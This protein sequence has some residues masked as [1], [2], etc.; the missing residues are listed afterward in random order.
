[1]EVD[2]RNLR[3]SFYQG[4]DEVH[5]FPCSPCAKNRMNVA[6]TKHCE[7][8]DENLCTKCLNHHN[9]FSLMKGDQLLDKLKSPSGHRPD[10]PSQ[11]CDRHGGKLIDVY[12]PSHDK[13]GCSTCIAVDHST[14]QRISFIPD[15][16]KH[17]RT[18]TKDLQ[19]LE[20][21]LSSLESR[22]IA[23]KQKKQK[24]LDSSK[25]EKDKL[26]HEINTERKKINEQLDKMETELLNE[27]DASFKMKMQ[28]IDSDIKEVEDTLAS[29][30]KDRQ[31]IQAAKSEN[32][33]EKYV[34]VKLGHERKKI[35]TYR[36]ETLEGSK[37]IGRL[38]FDPCHQIT[39]S[40]IN[41]IGQVTNYSPV[42]VESFIS[43]FESRVG[44][45][46]AICDITD[47]CLCA[48][49]NIVMTD[50]SNNRIKKMNESYSVT[51]S[52]T[53]SDNPFGICQID[54][55]LLAVTLINK[56]NVQFISQKKLM[57]LKKSFKVGDRCRGIAYNDGLIHVCCGGSR[58]QKEEGAGHIEVYTTTGAL[59]KSYYGEMECPGSI[60]VPSWGKEIYVTDG[61][62]V[63][64]IHK[65]GNRRVVVQKDTKLDKPTGFCLI[66]RSQVCIAGFNSKNIVLMS[67]DGKM[68]EELLTEKDGTRNTLSI[69]FVE[70][71]SRLVVSSFK[72][73]KIKVYSLKNC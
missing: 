9:K 55:S 7:Q 28:N 58:E 36:L 15:V 39:D 3:K 34:Q 19:Q 53:V 22:F 35:A 18:S 30:K 52:L 27:V 13:V 6:A 57:T 49:G 45:D 62:G 51:S 32:I 71:Q 46:N 5:D 41:S 26:L 16:A 59:M 44:Q 48:D 8:F 68:Y 11:S 1:M 20:T 61:Y 42:E 33:S 56:K 29:L 10:L 43:E 21:A 4:S 65:E 60:I 12:C 69:C 64:I 31:M 63:H 38:W 23:L 25:R 72:S 2:V 40:K 67:S 17:S 14:C 37:K 24:E 54:A 70:K 66:N 47:M 73:N 50:Y